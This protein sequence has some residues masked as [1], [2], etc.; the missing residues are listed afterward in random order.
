MSNFSPVVCAIYRRQNNE[1]KVIRVATIEKKVAMLQTMYWVF[2][3]EPETSLGKLMSLLEDFGKMSSYKVNIAKTQVLNLN[4]TPTKNV[5]EKYK[6][7]H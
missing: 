5:L 7:N 3:E 6:Q 1:V 4:F 2:S